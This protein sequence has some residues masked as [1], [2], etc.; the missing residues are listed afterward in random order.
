MNVIFAS[1]WRFIAE[2][3][4]MA[5]IIKAVIFLLVRCHKHDDSAQAALSNE[6]QI[7]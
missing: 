6:T 4:K 7:T 2:V 1:D 5:T 3:N